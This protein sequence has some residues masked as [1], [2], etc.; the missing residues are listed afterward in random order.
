MRN[1]FVDFA[2]GD[3]RKDAVAFADGQQ[4]RIQHGVHAAHDLCKRALELLRLAAIGKLAFLRSF[5]QPRHFSLQTLRDDG[6]VVYGQLHLFV[7][8]LVGLRNQLVDLACGDL[9]KDAIAFSDGQKNRIQHFVDAFDGV[10]LNALEFT[11][12]A[13]LAQAAFL[14]CIHQPHNLI[15]QAISLRVDRERNSVAYVVVG[16]S[17]RLPACTYYC[18]RHLF[19]PFF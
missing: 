6:H 2:C 11:G 15:Q 8:A 9:R 16:R 7:V 3:L 12:L 19:L 17:I 18:R 14:G 10:A 1:Q 5:N 13:A 4:N